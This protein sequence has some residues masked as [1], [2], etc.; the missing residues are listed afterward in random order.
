MT[1]DKLEEASY[2]H[3]FLS[4]QEM[5]NIP[6]YINIKKQSILQL[7]EKFLYEVTGVKKG[8]IS[9]TKHF[10]LQSALWTDH[11]V[12]TGNLKLHVYYENR[13]VNYAANTTIRLYNQSV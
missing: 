11:R 4:Y 9:T 5:S 7:L 2:T 12:V 10:K 3:E 13:T 6:K 1:P 8:V